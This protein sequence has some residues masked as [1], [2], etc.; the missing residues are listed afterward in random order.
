MKRTSC[1]RCGMCCIAT[2]CYAGKRGDSGHCKHLT[3]NSNLTTTC[4]RIKAEPEV[5]RSLVHNGCVL[6]GSKLYEEYL[7]IHHV[8]EIKRGI[9]QHQR[10]ALSA[11]SEV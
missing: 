9:L 7:K 6:G 1:V 5:K 3:V 4:E 11:G 8:G 10:K 2:L